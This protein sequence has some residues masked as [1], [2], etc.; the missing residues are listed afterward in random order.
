MTSREDEESD[1]GLRQLNA[2]SSSNEGSTNI[3]VPS[4]W[5]TWVSTPEEIKT[6]VMEE[7][8]K[9]S[10]TRKDT[11]SGTATSDW[12]RVNIDQVPVDIKDLA[13]P[14]FHNR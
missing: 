9:M 5:F 14:V 6:I 4:V 13:E 3:D 7:M 1:L 8:Q 11:K 12:T 2:E 10:P